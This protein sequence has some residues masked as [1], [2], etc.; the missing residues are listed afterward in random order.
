MGRYAKKQAAAFCASPIDMHIKIIKLHRLQPGTLMH[1][2]DPATRLFIMVTGPGIILGI[3]LARWKPGFVFM[4]S[5]IT[6]IRDDG[7]TCKKHYPGPLA[8]P[9]PPLSWPR[10]ATPE[11]YAGGMHFFRKYSILQG[12]RSAG[13]EEVVVWI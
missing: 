5:R 9:I 3:L 13:P 8:C 1:D 7:E 4:G 11:F 6:S 12:Q 10:P 2:P